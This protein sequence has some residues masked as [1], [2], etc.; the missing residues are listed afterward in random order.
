MRIEYQY[1]KAGA[2]K[3]DNLTIT[4][5]PFSAQDGAIP[6]KGDYVML[7]ISH[8]TE[9]KGNMKHF[10]IVARHFFY[11]QDEQNDHA[12]FIVTDAPDTP[13]MNFRE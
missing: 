6:Q 3:P 2:V 9:Q 10:E 8:P 1:L 13:E 11:G 12:I 7:P 4:D 5:A